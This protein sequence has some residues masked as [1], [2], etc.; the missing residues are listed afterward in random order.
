[1]PNHVTRW[2]AGPAT[3]RANAIGPATAAGPTT[4]S[5][6]SSVSDT[7]ATSVMLGRARALPGA[8]ELSRTLRPLKR[9]HPS[10]RDH[11]VD[12]EATVDYFC[13]TGVLI[14]VMQPGAEPWFDVDVLVDVGP[15]MEVWQDTARELVS[16]LQRH[17]AFREVR[18][19]TLEQA[20]DKIRLSHAVG[21]RSEATQLV[22]P[23]ARRL[24]VLVTDCIGPL[25]YEAPIWHAIR[26]WGL[27]APVVLVTMLPSRL[28]PQTALGSVEVTMRS[29]QPGS[30][31]RLLDA[32]LPW[33]WPDDNPPR[34]AMPL[35]VITLEAAPVAEWARMVMGAGGVE[36]PGVLATPPLGRTATRAD[37]TPLDAEERVRRFRVTVS[38][39]AYRLAMYLSAALRGR[40]RLDLA[41][42]VQQ[43]LLP[44][45]SQVHLAE[46][47]VG[48]LVRRA[49]PHAGLYEFTEGV[50]DV[51]RRSLTGTEA[52]RVLQVLGDYIE[53]E[54]GHS[55]GIAARLLGEPA[56]ADITEHFRDVRAGVDSL[57]REM[58]LARADVTPS[59]ATGAPGFEAPGS[60]AE[61]G[62]HGAAVSALVALPGGRLATGAEDGQLL[63]WDPTR[64]PPFGQ[65]LGRHSAAVTA[66]IALPDGRLASAAQD[67]QLLLWDPAVT[68]TAT[69]GFPP[70][71]E[72]GRHSAAVTALIAL[73]DGRLASAAEDGQLLL[74]DPA[75]TATATAGFPPAAELGRHSAA[76]TALIALPDGRLAS[77]AQ[78]GQ[79]LLW[80]PAV[81]ATATAGFPPAAELG[82]HSA[83]VTALIA[84][85]D[86]RLASAAQDGQL[87]LWDPAVT[88]TAT[89]GF[90][91]AAELGRHSAAVT[92][93]IAL[94][95]G[96]LA[97]AAQDG[98]L[99]LWDPAVTAT[100]TAGFPPPPSWAA[101]ARP[102]PP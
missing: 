57:I 97:S 34:A 51:L 66:L 2:T 29:H 72:L 13:D 8:L 37:D 60:G 10:K 75:V 82:R 78:D 92:A 30:A 73:P 40:W 19:W 101:T 85:P 80:D 52:L 74:W 49:D 67:G 46:V 17:G 98:Q 3:A 95:D 47:I 58:G 6:V 44:D 93:L 25:W 11:T 43:A 90:P 41:R 42:V 33:W 53:R 59:P 9:R 94:P 15:S 36:V 89:A 5:K 54:T 69:A 32:A 16:L 83:A 76:V 77:A 48:G 56:P 62:P 70:A 12:T 87:L 31:N 81:T 79:L 61:F 45:S 1:M 64:T 84:L 24:T 65:E 99:L 21:V 63:L 86:G 96:R 27:F 88:A 35:P 50:A 100:A 4:A 39:V 28:W 26:G 38:P 68:A 18:H 71:A 91:P 22:D 20:D 102:S 55:P 14:P 23:D 7:T